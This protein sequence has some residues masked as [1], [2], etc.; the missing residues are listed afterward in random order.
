MQLDSSVFSLYLRLHPRSRSAEV[1]LRAITHPGAT[2]TYS[3]LAN[4]AIKVAITVA[5]SHPHR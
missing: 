5:I 2:H 1:V 4:L 3:Q